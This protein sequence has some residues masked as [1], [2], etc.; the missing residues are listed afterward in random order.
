MPSVQTIGSRSRR[1]D[2]MDKACGR[3]RFASDEYPEGMLWAGALR[4]GV[5]HG[6][7]RGMDTARAKAMPGVVAVLT[8]EDVPGENRQ[9]FIHWDMPVLCGD[10]V[11]HAGDA[12]ALVVAET[13]EVLS[14]ALASIILDIES[15]PV[16][17][18]LDAALAPDA[19]RV[20]DL[21]TGNIL[22]EATLRKGDA[23][24][25]LTHC[26]VIVEET[27]F[28]PQQAHCFLETENGTARMDEDGTLHMTVSTQAPFRD[29]FEIGRALGLPPNR[30]HLTA[31]YLGGGF[32]GKDGATVQCLLA[33]AAMHAGGRPV[34]M[35]WSREE[36]LLAGYKRHAAR[37]HFRLGAEADGTLTALVCDLDYDTGAYAHLGVEIMA[38]GLEHASGPYRVEHLEANGRC[39]YTNNPVAGAFR[40]FG[41]AQVC[42]AFEGVMDR[43]AA[44]LDMDPLELRAKNA[45]RPGDRNGV[46]VGMISSTG[47][48][49]CLAGLRGHPFWQS[50]DQWVR[51]APPL[52]RRGVGI[53]AVHNGMGYGRGLADSAVAKVRLT[54][55]GR[56]RVYNSVSDMG[57]GNSPTFVQMACEIL[58]QDESLMELV[59]P[60]TERSHP[61][62]SSSAG[63]TTYTYGNALIKAC[64]AM[65]DKLLHRAAMVLMVDDASVLELVPGAVRHAVT[66]QELPLAALVGMLHPDDRF[67]I[68][69]AMMPVTQDV[70]EGGE[71][72]RLGF[73]HLIFPY[74]AHLARVEVDELTGNVSVSD[75]VAFTDGGRVLNPQNFEQQVQGAVAQGLGYALW[76]DCFAEGGR[77]LTTDLSNYVIP[78]AGD[79]PDIESHAVETEEQ[80]GPF[81]MKGIGEVGMNGPL[82]AVASALLRMGLPMTRAPFTPERILAAFDGDNS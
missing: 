43:L 3:E 70:P 6:V 38:L 18:G 75:Y 29:R 72:F 19:P 9:G 77:L 82:P 67:C 81:G 48:K 24:E 61:S 25:A 55:E 26:A 51:E 71:A 35:W 21:E 17:D 52:T 8:A 36:S 50:R 65:R 45:L 57:Q 31:P 68:G 37:M 27:F 30:L 1:F 78:G 34:K 53:A 46:G 56:F 47:M 5:P 44:K 4:A 49:E 15:L 13:R 2:A 62:G 66:G 14:E 80:S 58:Q 33:L 23:C 64:E 16:V 10:K 41:V 73:P 54:E 69:E 39:V 42:F 76:E 20:H 79:L 7:I 28:T 59:Q 11:R 63:R 22:K 60:D 32:G 40:G 74:A 12:V